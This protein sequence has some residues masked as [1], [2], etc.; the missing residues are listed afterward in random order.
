MDLD[1]LRKK[2][3]EIKNKGFIKANR[4]SDTGIGKTLEDLLGICENNLAIPDAGQFE[5]KSK[6][7]ESDS[8]LTL[9]T[10][11]PLPRGINKKLYEAFRYKNDEGNYC[12]HSTT[13]SSRSNP[14]GFKI[15]LI[16]SKIVLENRNN[17][18]AYWHLSIFEDVLV[19]KSNNILLI[20]AKSKGKSPNEY[21]HYTEAYLLSDLNF[22]KFQEAIKNDKLLVDIRI[23]TYKTGKR[24]GKYHDHGT[25][26]RIHKRD[27]TELYKNYTQII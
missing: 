2:L 10:K 25:A 12:L 24:Q 7:I 14:Q 6:R 13:Y 1:E 18:Q 8:M 3:I 21:F 16:E 4:T 20:F 19:S 22:T 23:G 27:F 26:F 15:S 17:I 11:S 5:I 9:A